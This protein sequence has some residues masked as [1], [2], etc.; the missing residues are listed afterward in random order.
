MDILW[1]DKNIIDKIV[2][3][4]STQLLRE[5]SGFGLQQLISSRYYCA[6]G[7]GCVTTERKGP[8]AGCCQSPP[9]Q[10]LYKTSACLI[11]DT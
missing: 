10:S 9:T 7:D 5:L 3:Y 4:H 1:V 2:H 8:T 11:E 6:A